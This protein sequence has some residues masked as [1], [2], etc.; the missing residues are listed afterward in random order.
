M[1][2]YVSFQLKGQDKMVFGP[3]VALVPSI[4]LKTM[5]YVAIVVIMSS[6]LPL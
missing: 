6:L 5:L 1:G 2:F 4:N 3:R